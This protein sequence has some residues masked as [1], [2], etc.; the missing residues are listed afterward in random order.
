MCLCVNGNGKQQDF[1]ITAMV[2]VTFFHEK[3]S[4]QWVAPAYSP[5]ASV[6]I[7]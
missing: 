6:I 1:P 5:C 7:Y 3:C 4:G 2:D